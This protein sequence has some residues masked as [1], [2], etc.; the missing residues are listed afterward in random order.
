MLM[1]AQAWQFWRQPWLLPDEEP[2][3]GRQKLGLLGYQEEA[4]R[5]QGQA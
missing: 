4:F 3:F 2:E 5:Y 1:Q